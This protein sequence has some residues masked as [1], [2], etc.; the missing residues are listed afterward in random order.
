MDEKTAWY[1][2][3]TT[4]NIEAYMLYQD[5][6]TGWQAGRSGP[7]S[8]SKVRRNTDRK[9]AGTGGAGEAPPPFSVRM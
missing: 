3:E 4:G 8:P 7:R 6:A 9:P 5:L 1:L 2:F